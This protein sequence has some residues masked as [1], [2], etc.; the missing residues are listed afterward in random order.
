MSI[1]IV[2]KAQ[3]VVGGGQL[4][5][6]AAGDAVGAQLTGGKHTGNITLTPDV[7]VPYPPQKSGRC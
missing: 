5:K 6:I 7:I 3:Q 1:S 4:V 2:T